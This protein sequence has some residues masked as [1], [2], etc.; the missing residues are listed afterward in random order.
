MG[1]NNVK[2]LPNNKKSPIISNEKIKLFVFSWNTNLIQF[3]DDTLSIKFLQPILEK[4]IRNNCNLVLLC[5]QQNSNNSEIIPAIHR[6]MIKL[7]YL[8][9]Y[10]DGKYSDNSEGKLK[11]IVFAHNNWWNKLKKKYTGIKIEKIVELWSFY[12]KRLYFT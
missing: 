8:M 4:I 5:L 12:R 6:V 7:G 11:M 1:N 2:P 9:P 3:K 10:V